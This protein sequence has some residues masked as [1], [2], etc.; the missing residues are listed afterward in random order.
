MI[1]AVILNGMGLASSP[2]YLLKNFFE[3]K[4]IEHL[5]GEGIKAEYFNDDRL[6]RVLDKIYQF[7]LN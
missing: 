1:K 2:L 3:S 5:L 6:R 7:G 4:S